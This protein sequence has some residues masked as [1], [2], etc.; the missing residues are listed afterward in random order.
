MS[1][2]KKAGAYWPWLV[3]SLLLLI[4]TI[5]I[6]VFFAATGDPSHVIV[7]DYY[8]KAVD[9]DQTAAQVQH[10]QELGWHV[11]LTFRPVPEDW[12]GAGENAPN[13]LV[14]VALVDSSG[15]LLKDAAI[16][17]HCFHNA[18][19]SQIREARLT[20]LDDGQAAAFRLGPPGLWQ[21]RL[22]ATVGSERFTWEEE[23]EL[24]QVK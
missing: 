24:G 9:W 7:E 14:H 2:P 23:R 1:Q 19:S 20:V 22:E 18:R 6:A 10:N 11:R 13:T 5:N 21:F 12:T 16:D 3:G 17:L 8:Q 4:L 15:L